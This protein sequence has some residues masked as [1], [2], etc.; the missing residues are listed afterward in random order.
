MTLLLVYS[1]LHELWQGL[2]GEYL[3]KK[4]EKNK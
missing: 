2:L 4:L 1:Q 3:Q